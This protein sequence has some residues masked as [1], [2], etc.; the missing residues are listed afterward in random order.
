MLTDM[1]ET[2]LANKE[3]EKTWTPKCK[4]S[5]VWNS[6]GFSFNLHSLLVRF[7]Q[8]A[9]EFAEDG[10]VRDVRWR[11]FLRLLNESF[12][13]ELNAIPAQRNTLYSF[14]LVFPFKT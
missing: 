7:E 4:M 2:V 9:R 1:T 6:F 11:V 8:F 12:E 14:T 5:C 3:A 10:E 13:N